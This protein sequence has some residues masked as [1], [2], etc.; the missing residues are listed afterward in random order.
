MKFASKVETPLKPRLGFSM[1]L[2]NACM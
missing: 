1:H 2:R